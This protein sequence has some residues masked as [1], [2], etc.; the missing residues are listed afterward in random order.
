[1]ITVTL[2]DIR[3][4]EFERIEDARGNLSFFENLHQI[5]FTIKRVEYFYDIPGGKGFKGYAYKNRKELIVALSGSFDVVID[6]GAERKVIALNR[7]YVGLYVP[8]L[9]WRQIKNFSTNSLA[10]VVTDA[11]YDES[12]HIR[13]L[14]EFT[15]LKNE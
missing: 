6:N 2:E 9:V 7:S 10:L 8:P 1:M 13:S 5:P 15:R 12:D 14:K 3:L 11:A 4:I